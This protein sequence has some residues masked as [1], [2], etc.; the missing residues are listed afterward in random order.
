[1]PS[2][3]ELLLNKLKEKPE[4]LFLFEEVITPAASIWVGVREWVHFFR[5]KEISNGDRIIL[6]LAESKAFIQILFACFW[7][8]I[9]VVLLNKDF[10][11]NSHLDFFDAKLVCIDKKIN[12]SCNPTEMGLPPKDFFEIRN[13]EKKYPEISIILK[14]SGSTGKPKFISLSEKNILSVL[15][16]HKIIFPDED[17][18]AFSS[19]PW[20]HS[21][22][23]VLDL[24]ILTFNANLIFRDPFSGKNLSYLLDNFEKYNINHFSTVPI[25]IEKILKENSGKEKLLKLNSGLVGGAP[26]NKFISENLKN[27]KLRVGYGQSEA[28]PGI[29]LGK[30]GKF[31]ENY[32]GKVLGTD[33]RLNHESILEFDGEN[34]FLGYY[35]E[36]GLEK[37]TTGFFSTGDIGEQKNDEYYFKGRI[38][39][40]FKLPSGILISPEVLE[41]DILELNHGLEKILIYFKEIFYI[42]YFSEEEKKLILPRF[43][44]KFEIKMIY[45]KLDDLVLTSKGEL[46]RKEILEKEF[47]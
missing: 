19:L 9:T 17:I 5:E 18:L 36:F 25:L 14:S 15:E 42:I 35:T 44:D 20:T 29:C 47:L 45:K 8:G 3:K 34:K 6:S 26:I 13:S 27:S 16:S 40:S 37:S 11:E 1:M 22:G 30:I 10:F 38:D 39:F 4:P 12:Y 21:F 46:N 2:F 23:L 24:L 28:S 7:E 31:E 41:K 43:F 32:I 33:I